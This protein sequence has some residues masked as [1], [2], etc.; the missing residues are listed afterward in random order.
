MFY[1]GRSFVSSSSTHGLHGEGGGCWEMLPAV[2]CEQEEDVAVFATMREA[3]RE[4]R[5]KEK[6]KGV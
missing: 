3:E 2:G 4:S 6:G 1:G 5:W